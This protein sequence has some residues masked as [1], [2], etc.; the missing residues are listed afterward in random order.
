MKSAEQLEASATESESLRT[1]LKSFDKE[2]TKASKKYVSLFQIMKKAVD[3]I[4]LVSVT[5]KNVVVLVVRGLD[6]YCV[7][8]ILHGVSPFHC[9]SLSYHCFRNATPI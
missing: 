2:M 9:S 7:H 6:Y 8:R 3:R 4:V 1:K 5:Y